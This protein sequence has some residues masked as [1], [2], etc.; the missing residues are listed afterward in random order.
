MTPEL[1]VLCTHVN[2]SCHWLRLNARQGTEWHLAKPLAWRK[3]SRTDDTSIRIWLEMTGEEASSRIGAFS[4]VVVCLSSRPDERFASCYRGFCL[5][6]TG[7]VKSSEQAIHTIYECPVR[8]KSTGSAEERWFDDA[9]FAA[10]GDELL[11]SK[12]PAV[13]I[14]ARKSGDISGVILIVL[15][16]PVSYINLAAIEDS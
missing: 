7:T 14:E 16:L 11:D 8:W 4:E 1:D 6:V 13:H 15:T 2:E 3:V 5:S 9:T 10:S 12:A